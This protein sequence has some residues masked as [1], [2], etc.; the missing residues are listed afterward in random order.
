MDFLLSIGVD[1]SDAEFSAS[2]LL[3]AGYKTEKYLLSA[4]SEHLEKVGIP[5]PVIDVILAHQEE[6]G[7]SKRH[8]RGVGDDLELFTDKYAERIWQSVL[9]ITSDVDGNAATSLVFDVFTSSEGSFLYLLVNEHYHLEDDNTYYLEFCDSD[10][11]F[12]EVDNFQRDEFRVFASSKENDF[13]IYKLALSNAIWD[14]GLGMATRKP[15]QDSKRPRR[16][17]QKSAGGVP[18][19]PV[20]CKT[21]SFWYEG[22]HPSD[23]VR[24]YA[25]PKAIPGRWVSHT[26]VTHVGK[27]IFYV[28]ALSAPAA[29]GG[30][31]LATRTGKVVGFIGGAYDVLE[32][33]SM[34]KKMVERRFNS[35][36]FSVL[37][38]P[39]RP[40]SPPTSPTRAQAA[41]K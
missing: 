11:N 37:V 20:I 7:H 15:V 22:I 26:R 9:R 6:I 4:K 13:V 12:V 5:F 28:Q 1:E 33:N 34:D 14:V 25:L 38:L 36:A 8:S 23:E 19:A 24:V 2:K 21:P 41:G 39:D 3:G 40:S 16:G 17:K 10:N 30:A 32:P 31:V 29:S 35:F 27:L 18:K